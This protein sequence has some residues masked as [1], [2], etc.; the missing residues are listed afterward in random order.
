MFVADVFFVCETAAVGS[1]MIKAREIISFSL[2]RFPVCSFA[3]FAV[4]PA[5]SKSEL[6]YARFINIPASFK[7]VNLI[8]MNQ[9]SEQN[10]LTALSQ[11]IDPDLK[12]DI[13]TLGFVKDL[14][15]SGGDVSFALS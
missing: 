2:T 4:C 5:Q 13:V 12:K 9:L 1:V 15:I 6:N 7:R 8:F 10:I 3:G 11:I 14:A